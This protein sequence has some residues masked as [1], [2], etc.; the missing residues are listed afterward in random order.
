[1]IEFVTTNAVAKARFASLNGRKY[2][3]APCT[4][5]QEGVLAGSQG[6]LYYPPDEIGRNYQ[7]WHGIPLTVSHPISNDGS[8]L[9]ANE[10]DVLSRQGIGHFANPI[11]VPNGSKVKGEA[12]IDIERARKINRSILDNLHAGRPVEISTGLYTDNQPAPLGSHF[13]GKPYNHIARNYRPDHLAILPNEIGAC[14]VKDGCGLLVN[15]A[16][17]DLAT[18]DF[19]TLPKGIVGT[20]CSNC[21][22]EQD[23]ECTYND[24]T[25]LR[26]L[27]VSKH[28]CCAYWDSIGTKRDWDK[29]LAVSKPTSN[30]LVTNES[31]ASSPT[32]SVASVPQFFTTLL[33]AATSAHILHLSTRSFAAH[34]AME[35]LYK[36]LPK[37]VDR[38]IEVWQGR[39]D[40]VSTWP[41]GY[42]P[43]TSDPV[44]FVESLCEYLRV[45]RETLG[46][47]SVIQNI[48][49]DIASLLD[50]VLYKTRFLS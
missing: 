45:S 40:L 19:V 21:R 41:S 20:N 17:K 16:K 14:S 48:V 12:W 29:D 36:K 50:D 4:I 24:K 39:N 13:N 6:A 25:D 34:M 27:K 9:S 18:A 11:L 33:H 47:C 30:V 49:D 28:T 15:V 32:S 2:L 35:Q 42:T 8:H 46:D 43:P 31:A 22:F 5:L 7:A 1:M 38:L 44:T 10:G 3:V 37:K 23:G 26:G